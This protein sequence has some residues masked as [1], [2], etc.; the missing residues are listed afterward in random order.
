MLANRRPTVTLT[1]ASGKVL[2]ENHP[3]T[4][5]D[6]IFLH[7]ILSSGIPLSMTLRGGPPFKDTPGLVWSI[8]GEKGEIRVTAGGPFLQIGY[9]EGG[10]K[11]EVHDFEGGKVEKVEVKEE[12]GDLPMPGRNVGRVYRELEAGQINCSFED[13]VERHEFIEGLYKE[14]GYVEA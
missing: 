6:T 4:A 12:L 10:I 1:D 8:Y 7:G 9:G 5:D 11:V 3:K 14:N 13:A 2:E